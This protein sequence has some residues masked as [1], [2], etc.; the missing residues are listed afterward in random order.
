MIDYMQLTNATTELD[1]S[2]DQSIVEMPDNSEWLPT[3]YG[4][5]KAGPMLHI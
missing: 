2:I 3:R 1:L 4:K 5:N